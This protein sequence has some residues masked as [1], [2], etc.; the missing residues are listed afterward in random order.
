MNLTGYRRN[1]RTIEQTNIRIA[2]NPSTSSGQV[3]VKIF[4]NSFTTA[5]AIPGVRRPSVAKAMEGTQVCPHSVECFRIRNKPINKDPLL[6][7]K[8]QNPSSKQNLK[9]GK[10]NSQKRHNIERECN[11][12]SYSAYAGDPKRITK[13]WRISGMYANGADSL[14]ALRGKRIKL[15]FQFVLL[16]DK[17]S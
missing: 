17:I 2:N 9:Q 16:S 10:P 14:A 8:L 15:R 7:S 11:G 3:E 6:N 5:N 12:K 1:F 13:D 4:R